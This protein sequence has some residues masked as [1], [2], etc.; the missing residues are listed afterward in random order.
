MARIEL[1]EFQ[2]ED[3][4]ETTAP[5]EWLYSH[6]G[7]RLEMKQLSSRMT[8]AAKA[9]GIRNFLALFNEYLE[10]VKEA[11]DSFRGENATDFDGQEQS[12]WCGSWR[13]DDGGVYGTDRFGF[14]IVAC[15]HPILPVRRLTNIDSGLVKVELA[16]RRGGAWRRQIFDKITISDARS[17]IKLSNFDVAVNS[18]N[19][20]YLVKYLGEVENLNY[21]SIPTANSV[22]R[23]GWI[24]GYGFS[25]YVKELVFDG[26]EDYRDRFECVR[27][28]GSYDKWLQAIRSVRKTEGAPTRIALAA[29]FASVLVRPCSCLPFLVHLWGGSET[30]KSVA[31]MMAASVWADPEIGRF[32]QTFN[33]TSVGKELGAAFYNS[34]PLMLDELQIIDGSPAN[35]L[36]FQQMIYELAEGVGRSRGKRDGGLQKVGTWRNCIMS[37]GEHPLIDSNTAAGAA[38]RTIE[39]CCQDLKFFTSNCIGNGKAMAA[40]LMRNYG[41]AGRRF[42]EELQREDNMERAVEM[43]NRLTD[44]IAAYGD[45]TDKQSASG[46]LLL[47]AD[48]LAEKWI[49]QDGI[50]LSVEDIVPFLITKTKMDQNRR[51][52]EFL[53]DQIAMNPVR[54]DPPRAVEKSVELWGDMDER[55]IYIIKPQFDRL[56]GENGYNAGSF[57]GWARQNGIIRVGKDGKSTVTHRVGGGKPARCVVLLAASCGKVEDDAEED[58]LLPL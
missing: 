25:P 7:N 21:G 34:L 6:R 50:T 46:A 41:F 12:L 49:F 2:R 43:Q 14:E 56:L 15:P 23:L 42:V 52:L 26:K 47:T 29:S 35:R 13:A 9:V 48:I 33:G 5:Y 39:I 30:G 38:N 22:G 27:E 31:L 4:L 28:A 8:E 37:T 57:L 53:H 54:F 11:G 19:A 44:E 17:I 32:V 20:K 58:D 1:P 45:V 55:Y 3:Y 24:D 36:K 16:Y 10:A 51:A 40:F 18:D